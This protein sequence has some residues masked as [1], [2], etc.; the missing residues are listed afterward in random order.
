M[1]IPTDNEI[2]K[3]FDIADAYL[4][5]TRLQGWTWKGAIKFFKEHWNDEEF[6]VDYLNII[7]E[8]EEV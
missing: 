4:S 1:N 8:D 3:M 6:N 7:D 2:C 5:E